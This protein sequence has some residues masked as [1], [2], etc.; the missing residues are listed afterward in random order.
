MMELLNN[1]KDYYNIIITIVSIIIA[2]IAVAY[3]IKSNF[4]AQISKFI[5]DAQDLELTGPEK[6]EYVISWIKDIIPRLFKVI[7]NDKTLNQIAQNIYD[8]MKEY[9]RKRN[10]E[11]EERKN[12][13]NNIDNLTKENKS[14]VRIMS[15]KE[16][17]DQKENKNKDTKEQE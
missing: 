5:A 7:F 12:Q 10:E 11:L 15:M 8:D 3:K 1:I 16:L 14:N 2:L 4:V 17:L 6:M 9:A 13:S